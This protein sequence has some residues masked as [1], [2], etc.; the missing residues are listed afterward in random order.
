MS[1]RNIQEPVVTSQGAPFNGTKTT[2]PAFAMIGAS[3]VSGSTPLFGSD[4]IHHNYIRV[5][6]ANASLNRNTSHD[7]YHAESTPYIEVSLSEAQWATFVSSMNVGDGVPCTL[8]SLNGSD[9]PSI[10]NP[11]QRKDQSV[12]EVKE[13]IENALASV[14]TLREKIQAM[15]ASKKQKDSLLDEVYHVEMNIR[16]NA[17]CMME[18]FDEHMEKTIEKAKIEVNAYA[19]SHL[20]QLGL[21]SVQQ[22]KLLEENKK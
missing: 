3:R 8:N 4:F 18:C 16:Q 2:H 20:M 1:H 19:T 10:P 9:V 13:C 6:I 11:K 7:W 14:S 12:S 17:P 5:R 22:Q 15:T 21:E